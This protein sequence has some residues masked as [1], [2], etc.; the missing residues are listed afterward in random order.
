M[1]EKKAM[2]QLSK[3][4]HNDLLNQ[5]QTN[6]EFVKAYDELADEIALLDEA[7]K[8]RKQQNLTQTE[9]ASRMGLPRSAV[10]RLENGLESGKMPTLS[11]LRRYARALGKR[12]EIR[13]VWF[14]IR[15]QTDR[16]YVPIHVEIG[17]L[18]LIFF[19]CSLKTDLRMVLG[20][21]WLRGLL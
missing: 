11:M 18:S 4:T 19:H 20:Q 7:I 2:L 6:P 17:L 16:G 21:Q 13:L 5:W 3:K 9:I 15:C 10:C 8:L 12:V 1:R 14:S